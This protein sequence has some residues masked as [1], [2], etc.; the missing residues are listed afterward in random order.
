MQERVSKTVEK[1]EDDVMALYV[2]REKNILTGLSL[3]ISIECRIVD[4]VCKWSIMARFYLDQELD[5][6][7]SQRPRTMEQSGRS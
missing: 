7:C 5:Q 2:P 4:L 1:S 6:I 3:Y